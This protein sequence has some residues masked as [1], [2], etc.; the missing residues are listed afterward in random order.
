VGHCARIAGQLIAGQIQEAAQAAAAMSRWGDTHAE[1]DIG[2]ELLDQ[3]MLAQAMLC[4]EVSRL[5]P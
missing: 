5:L 1:Y 2:N 3:A 4:N